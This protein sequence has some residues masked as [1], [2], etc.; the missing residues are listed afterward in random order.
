MLRAAA[1]AFS[2]FRRPIN[3]LRSLLSRTRLLHTPSHNDD[4][5]QRVYHLRERALDLE[6]RTTEALQR[7][8][9]SPPPPRTPLVDVARLSSPP[10]DGLDRVEQ[11]GPATDSRDWLDSL[12]QRLREW[13]DGLTASRRGEV[14]KGG[15][16][17]GEDGELQGLMEE[18]STIRA[19]AIRARQRANEEVKVDDEE[20]KEEKGPTLGPIPREVWEGPPE[21]VWLAIPLKGDDIEDVPGNG[22]GVRDLMKERGREEAG[23]QGEKTDVITPLDRKEGR[24]SQVSGQAMGDVS[25]VRRELPEDRPIGTPTEER[26]T[27]SVPLRGAHPRPRKTRPRP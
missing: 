22:S 14:Q 11:P 2:H 25:H 8:G 27:S 18:A 1:T 4:L 24:E 15:K 20:E 3:T 21:P 9:D 12:V 16:G 13:E 7:L 19:E 17:A 5:L 10:P 26:G 23:T 6:R